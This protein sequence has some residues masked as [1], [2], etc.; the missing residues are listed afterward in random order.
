MIIVLLF[1]LH[2]VYKLT[3]PLQHK[4]NK[5]NN[6]NDNNKAKAPLERL[7]KDLRA[8]DTVYIS[9][10]SLFFGIIC[11]GICS[12]ILGFQFQFLVYHSHT[13]REREIKRER[14]RGRDGFNPHNACCCR[15]NRFWIPHPLEQ[16]KG[17]GAS[18]GSSSSS[19]CTSPAPFVVFLLPLPL[20]SSSS[21]CYAATQPLMRLAGTR[22]MIHDSSPSPSSSSSSSSASASSAPKKVTLTKAR[23][24]CAASTAN[25]FASLTHTHRQTHRY[26]LAGPPSWLSSSCPFW[27]RAN[28][29]Y[30]GQATPTAAAPTRFE[31]IYAYLMSLRS[32]LSNPSSASC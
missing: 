5:N 30:A 21:A 16:N 28:I 15:S 11:T 29:I 13:E 18:R 23:D 1:S 7:L 32:L 26:D 17:K 10:L 8:V 19:C 12:T 4:S 20:P 27:S 14:G 9:G 31:K 22:S 25:W 2:L 24:L 3:L 6:N